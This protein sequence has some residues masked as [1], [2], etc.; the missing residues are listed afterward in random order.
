MS[1]QHWRHFTQQT[2]EG[3]TTAHPR[4]QF[5]TN[6]KPLIQTWIDSGEQVLIRMDINEQVNHPEV[7]NYFHSVGLMEAILHWHGQNAPPTHQCGSKAIDGI[8]VTNGLLGHPSSYL[9]SLDGIA[10]DHHCLWINLP[11]HWLFGGNMLVIIRPGA[12]QLK[13][14][15]LCTCKRYLENLE[16]YFTEHLLL[17]KLQQ[18]EQD[19]TEQQLQPH[20]KAELERLDNLWIQGMIQAEWQ[21][22]KL[23]T[24]P[25]GWTPELTRIKAEI[26]YWRYSLRQV[27]GRPVNTWLMY[28]LA[29]ALSLPLQPNTTVEIIQH[30]LQTKK[31]N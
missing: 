4:T 9:S 19:L 1:Q 26:K 3:E 30:Q 22:R 20:H 27:E 8:F 17:Q 31:H 14:D 24:R 18:I 28:H 5:W 10:G 29:K 25:Y 23:H 16:K 12:R 21:C 13:S 2:Q 15:S 7:T 11:E 6:L